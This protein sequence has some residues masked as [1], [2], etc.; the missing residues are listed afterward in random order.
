MTLVGRVERPRLRG[1]DSGRDFTA[2]LETTID[3]LLAAFAVDPPELF[4][5]KARSPSCGVGTTSRSGRPGFDGLFAERIAQAFPRTPRA[6]ETTLLN[7]EGRSQIFVQLVAER[8]A[9]ARET[10]TLMALEAWLA[11]LTDSEAS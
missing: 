1:N 3:V 6:D 7:F 2:A 4:L 9:K 5:L 11:T 8:R 10:Q